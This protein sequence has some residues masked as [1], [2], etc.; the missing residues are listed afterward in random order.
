MRD[1]PFSLTFGKEPSLMINRY[2]QF[3]EIVDAFTS[4]T[5][6]QQAFMITGVRGAGK[7]VFMSSIAKKLRKEK[8]WIV[9]D[10]NSS[11]ALLNELVA[12]LY[13][14]KGMSSMFAEAGINLS[15]WGIG[16]NLKKTTP[17][18][19]IG[20]AAERMLEK[21]KKQG[22]RVLITIDE[23]INNEGM[24][25]FAGVYQIMVRH[26]LPVFL[27]MTGLYENINSLQNEKNLTFLFR[28]PKM[29][30][31]VLNTGS[32]ATSY[33]KTLNIP[34]DE[35]NVYAKITKGYSYAF[36]VIGYFLYEHKG[37]YDA[38]LPEIRGYLDDY[39]YEK[40]WSELSPKET[41]ILTAL[42]ENEKGDVKTLKESLDISSNAFSVY[43]DRLIKKGILDGSRRGYVTFALPYFDE[44]V[45]EH[46]L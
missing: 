26:D 24:K 28:T 41:E 44:Y 4:A 43:R 27:L 3:N 22:K 8:E 20:T 2:L 1:N 33:E 13:N 15:F 6:S 30:L 18:T 40:L 35:A 17:I 12:K 9:V 36:Q 7:T 10:L 11:G 19:D 42:S 31:K 45:R 14:E 38:A 23:V 5:P 29:Y 34:R 16:I 25:T 37:D 32:I 21:L 46:F 39:V